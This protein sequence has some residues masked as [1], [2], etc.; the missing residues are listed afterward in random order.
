MGHGS[1]I[2]SSQGRTLQTT[3]NA[4]LRFKNGANR[5][6]SSQQEQGETSGL[7]LTVTGSLCEKK[8]DIDHDSKSGKEL[9][10]QEVEEKPGL[11]KKAK[12]KS[13]TNNV[14]KK[15]IA[16]SGSKTRKISGAGK[17][18]K[19]VNAVGTSPGLPDKNTTGKKSTH[20]QSNVLRS[21]LSGQIESILHGAVD[22]KCPLNTKLIRIFISSTF[23]DT[24]HERN[25]LMAKVYPKLKTHCKQYGY[26]FQTL[27]ADKYG[28]C[29]IPP[30][31]ETQEF[32]Q[33]MTAVDNQD[34]KELFHKWYR[35]DL[36]AIPASYVLQP[37]TTWY[38]DY[39][40]KTENAFL[41]DKS[42][43]EW[44]IVYEELKQSLLT[45]VRKVFS[46]EEKIHQYARSV[47]EAEIEEGILKSSV[48]TSKCGWLHRQFTELDLSSQ[49]ENTEIMNYVDRTENDEN[50]VNIRQLQ[51]NLKSGIT[52]ALEGCNVVTYKVK[53]SDKG[54]DP[55]TE[56]HKT[57]LETFCSDFENMLKT[58]ITKNIDENKNSAIESPLYDE[59]CQHT[60][61]CQAKIVMFHGRKKTL[62]SVCEYTKGSAQS[63]LV[64]YGRSGCG[65]TSIIAKSAQLVQEWTK[66]KACIVLRFLG[67]TA[68]SSSIRRILS[69]VLQQIK[70]VYHL[71]TKVPKG[72]KSLIEAF[73]LFLTSATEH[74][75]LIVLFDSLDQL[76]PNGGA[77]Q[78]S[79][80]P[81][82]LPK[83]V[84]FIVSTLP[85]AEF[86][87]YPKLR[88]VVGSASASDT[89]DVVAI[90]VVATGQVVVGSASASDT[91]DIVAIS[92][93]ATD[94]VVVGSA[95]ASDTADVVAI[96]VVATGQVVVGSASASDTAD[97][98]AISVVATDQV[99]VG[100]ASASDTADVVAISVVA[101]GQMVVGSASASDTADV[102]AISVVATGQVVVGSASASDTA[103]VVAISVVATDQVVVG[104]ASASDTADVVA[105]SVV[106][107]G[108]VVYLAKIAVH[109]NF[110]A[111]SG[112]TANEL[113]D[114]L[115]SNDEVLDDIF[116]YWTPPIRRLPPLIWVR[117]RADLDSYLVYRGAEGARVT[118]WYHRQFME[119]AKARYLSDDL[120]RIKL[121]SHIADYFTGQAYDG[122]LV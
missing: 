57:Y 120:Q 3:I 109:L 40:S 12:K 93:V 99:V 35:E 48:D 28:Y 80:L 22:Q 11:Q 63:P 114:I 92:V 24:Q 68:R 102:V 62:Q 8:N 103:D 46:D 112:L 98:V 50:G 74:K 6:R 65:K 79:W 113:E 4:T 39:F 88:V 41:R 81:K 119:A 36:N 69:T 23:T 45:A 64:L 84:K 42:H 31:I 96:S 33:I 43:Q 15:C 10:I 94:Q 108:Q 118:N 89:G 9:S 59:V 82:T 111:R 101:T 95:S 76:S 21:E 37:V 1:S 51:D 61:F 32:Q 115:S 91:A 47:S 67:T 13:N 14:P 53:W 87:C 77:R 105:I 38:P 100:S 121:H 7:D 55:N 29:P 90:S 26:E 75:P 78:L 70:S 106:A 44:K 97:V 56:E 110:S 122:K 52:K 85:D 30:I 18:G 86:R 5:R 25:E 107:T 71:D 49:P 17:K 20:K 16:A 2:Q 34:T 27:L 104:S 83:H 60:L 73:P 54:I 66:E 72:T 117:I 116:Q 19:Q 58:M